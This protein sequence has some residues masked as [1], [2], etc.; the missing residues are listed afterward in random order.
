MLFHFKAYYERLRTRFIAGMTAVFTTVTTTSSPRPAQPL[1]RSASLWRTGQRRL[2]L[3]SRPPWRPRPVKRSVR[4]FST[5]CPRGLST[6]APDRDTS[7]SRP[8]VTTS[9]CVARSRPGSS[10]Q[11]E[12]SGE[13]EPVL[14]TCDVLYCTEQCY[15]VTITAHGSRVSCIII[16][17]QIL[18]DIGS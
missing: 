9:L 11:R 2:G 1:W 16:Y 17:V 14:Y 8:A 12:C 13:R 3:T 10:L 5:W 4:R 18:V 7:V 15:N 6:P